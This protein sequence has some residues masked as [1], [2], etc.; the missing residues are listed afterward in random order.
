VHNHAKVFKHERK[1][2]KHSWILALAAIPAL[3]MAV[4]NPDSTFYTKAT[5]SNLAEIDGGLLA[6]QKSKRPAVVA[7]AAMAVKD[8]T[9]AN[10]QLREIAMANNVDLPVAVSADQAAKK[11]ELMGLSGDAFDRTYIEW[12]ILAH[13]D[14]VALFKTESETG[15]DKDARQFA[16]D[17][18]PTL[19]LHLSK[20]LAMPNIPPPKTAAP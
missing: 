15:D 8:H 19:Q 13:K 1:A 6:Q 20:L 3:A 12:Q 11:A 10:G 18:L 5:Q 9:S 4:D 17:T 16:T 14:A 7:F 2:M